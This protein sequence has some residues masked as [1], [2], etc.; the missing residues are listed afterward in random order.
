MARSFV[1][2]SALFIAIVVLFATE[3]CSFRCPRQLQSQT[4]TLLRA[5][6]HQSEPSENSRRDDRHFSDRRKFISDGLSGLVGGASVGAV[7]SPPLLLLLLAPTPGAST[8][9]AAT[10]PTPTP[11]VIA[12]GAIKIT[13]IAHTFVTTGGM[14]K[15]IRENDATRFFTNAR[16]VYLFEGGS[17][18][19]NM[20][21]EVVDL[22]KKRKA[23]RGP[24]VTPGEVETLVG[25]AQ[26][27]WKA[28][29]SVSQL[30]NEV[31]G[32]AKTMPDGDVLLVG[33][34]P[35]GG[36]AADGTILAE[37]AS[38][39][40]TF[41]GGKREKGIIS[42]LFDGPKENLKLVESGFPASELL[43]YSLP[44]KK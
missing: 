32:K 41:V 4:R 36:T 40:D 42:V 26:L 1:S 25:A 6:A 14:P 16:V 44:S 17:G 34:I 20:V 43:W 3:S 21:Q 24:G 13:P 37:T 18:G 23:D 2:V 10:T 19:A 5:F 9:A 11:D 28:G 15:P 7:S 12:T 38:A 39:L 27:K 33:P 22:T 29:G 31:A 35:S 8:A 30:V